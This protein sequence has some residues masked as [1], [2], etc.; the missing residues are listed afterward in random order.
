MPEII[1]SDIFPDL[2]LCECLRDS[3]WAPVWEEQ[4]RD[5]GAIRDKGKKERGTQ[6]LA[7]ATGHLYTYLCICGCLYNIYFPQNQ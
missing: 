2:T 3:G 5:K 4:E 1:T 7:G 6:V